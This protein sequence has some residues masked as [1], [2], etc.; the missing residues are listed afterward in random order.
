MPE[1]LD[2]TDVR[3]EDFENVGVNFEQSQADFRIVHGFL[4]M[5]A[6]NVALVFVVLWGF[7]A[8]F[9]NREELTRKNVPSQNTY[10]VAPAVPAPVLQSDPVADFNEMHIA[11]D[12]RLNTY[13]WVDK[14]AGVARIPINR[15]MD[16]LVERGLP[17]ETGANPNPAVGPYPGTARVE[18]NITKE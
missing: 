1:N 12:Q 4:I 5:L 15:A 7:Y 11:D 9:R 18:Q 16:L 6:I 14:K 8:W 10:S 17:V 3:E 2:H 13:S